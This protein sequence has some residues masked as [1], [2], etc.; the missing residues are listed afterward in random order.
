MMKNFRPSLVLVLLLA[1]VYCEARAAAQKSP[2]QVA[3]EFYTLVVRE[4]PSGLPEAR[5]MRLFAPYLSRSLRGL[6]AG[7][8]KEQDEAVRARPD[9]KPPNVD[10]CL[11]SCLFE[12]PK[13]FRLNKPRLEGRFAYVGVEQSGEADGDVKWTDTL[14]LVKERGR[15]LVWDIRM[16]CSWA[17]RMGPT[18]RSMLGEK[19]I[20]DGGKRPGS[21]PVREAVRQSK[22][23]QS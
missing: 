6:F 19:R 1:P 16:G 8:Q 2:H 18:L 12:G 5:Q 14:V 22:T 23:A 7:A 9:E 21:H 20:G 3:S 17:F 10:G 13:R 4:D 15:W 11:F